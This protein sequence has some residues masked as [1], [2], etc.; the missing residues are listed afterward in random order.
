MNGTHLFEG[1]AMKVGTSSEVLFVV[2]RDMVLQ[3][4]G[5]TGDFSSLHTDGQFGRKTVYRRNVVH[6]I[7]PVCF[8]SFLDFLHLEGLACYPVEIRAQFLEPIHEDRR[9]RLRGEVTSIDKGYGTVAVHFQIEDLEARSLCTRG[10]ARFRFEDAGTVREAPDP[11]PVHDLRCMI[12][13]PPKE[14][15]FTIDRISMEDKDGFGFHIG[16]DSISTFLRIL[17]EGTNADPVLPNRAFR[18]D[19]GFHFPHLLATTLLSTSVGMC[20]PGRYA[21]FLDF[22]LDFAGT[23]ATGTGYHLSGNVTHVSRSTSIVKKTISISSSDA[24][25]VL[26][27]GKINVLVNEPPP[28]MPSMQSIREN[29]TDMGL[30][31]KAVLVTGASRGIGETI[32]KMFAAFGSAVAVNYFLGKEDAERIVEEIRGEGGRAVAVQCD[33]TDPAQVRRM[34]AEVLEAYGTVDVL[35]NNAVRDFLP[36]KFIGLPWE[37]VQKDI[38]VVAK[39]AFHCC[40]E[41]IPVMLRQGGGKI[42]NLSTVATENPPP[43]QVKYVVAKSALV[44]LTRSLAAEFA[45]RNIQVNM[46]VPGFVDTDLVSYISRVYKKKIAEETPMR[47]IATPV[48]V[49]H[50]AIFLAS[51]FSSFTTGQKIL[52]TGGG[53][54]YL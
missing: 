52:V 46:V 16:E 9:L 12:N 15:D 40:Q 20:R 23:L 5:L 42:I 53:P 47:R 41:V 48:D 43:E 11:H 24:K 7:L 10:E 54:P 37:E 26:A 31:G 2:S 8:L 50:A 29:S 1:T 18:T 28:G 33:V 51:T 39:G 17:H 38:D 27:A 3:F 45:S 13:D 44:G 34:V 36:A 21:T 49:A 35:V 32:V 22:K 6:G 25:D 19:A 30:K 14:S 4:A